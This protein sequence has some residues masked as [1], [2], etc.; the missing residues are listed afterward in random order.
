MIKPLT[1]RK[2]LCIALGAFATIIAANITLAVAAIGSFPGI[3]VKNGYIASQYF[4]DERAAQEAL[5]WAAMA[6]HDG[7]GL[8]IE[9]HD[10]A[11][12]PLRL[13]A[14]TARVGRLSLIHI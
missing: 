6:R 3:E 9:I 8:L 11:G 14:L 1:G 12:A 10:A 4:E 5:G 7:D 2:V 13:D